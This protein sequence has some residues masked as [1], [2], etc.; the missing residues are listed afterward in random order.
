MTLQ[1]V[2]LLY[3]ILKEENTNNSDQQRE[4]NLEWMQLLK[5]SMETSITK[6]HNPNEHSKRKKTNQ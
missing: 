3:C 1:E 4:F 6:K 2:A 5:L